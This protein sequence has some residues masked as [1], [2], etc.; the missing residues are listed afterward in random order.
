VDNK[1]WISFKSWLILRH[2]RPKHC[3]KYST[4]RQT[5]TFILK[6]L[7]L[8]WLK[9]QVETIKKSFMS[10][11]NTKKYGGFCQKRTVLK[12]RTKVFQSKWQKQNDKYC[13][14]N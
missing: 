10:S 11:G 7:V 8:F 9:N 14:C 1:K 6:K 13:S 5:C 12:Q 3:Y 2:K 4:G